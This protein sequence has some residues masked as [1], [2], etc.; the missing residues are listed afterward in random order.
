MICGAMSPQGRAG[1]L[2]L[3]RVGAVERPD[4]QWQ[5]ARCDIFPG[6]TRSGFR[7]ISRNVDLLCTL[8]RLVPATA[9]LRRPGTGGLQAKSIGDSRGIGR[10][11]W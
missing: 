4:Y 3:R 9:G 2:W 1:T 8:L 7:A 6:G 11:R 5:E 10:R